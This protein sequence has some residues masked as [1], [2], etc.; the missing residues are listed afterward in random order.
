MSQEATVRI[1]SCNECPYGPDEPVP[2][3]VP[4]DFDA[5]CTIAQRDTDGS[6][7]S[8]WVFPHFSLTGNHEVCKKYVAFQ[9]WQEQKKPQEE[10]VA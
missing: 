10:K 3:K 4:F 5:Y 2:P 7:R 6:F 9:E 8:G 1:C